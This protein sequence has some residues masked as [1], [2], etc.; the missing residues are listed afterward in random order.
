VRNVRRD[1]YRGYRI[2]AVQAA[3]SGNWRVVIYPAQICLP[4]IEPHAWSMV[5]WVPEACGA[6]VRRLAAR[7]A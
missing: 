1:D 5:Y 2:E 7:A 4:C 3:V 6:R